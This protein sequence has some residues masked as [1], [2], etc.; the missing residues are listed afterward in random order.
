MPTT[1]TTALDEM[2]KNARALRPA[3]RSRRAETDQLRRL[4]QASVEDILQ[5][6][7][8]GVTTPV[9][10]GGSDLG[11]SAVFE[12]GKELAQGCAAT[13]WIGGNWA[14]HSTLAAMFS[15]EAQ[16]ELFTDGR[17]PLIA[18]AFSPLRAKTELVNGGARV[19]GQ[20]DFAS[21]I[22]HSDWVVVQAMTD[23]GPLA[24]L[25][26]VADIEVIETWRTNGLRGSGSNDVTA[27]EL[28]VPEHRL[29]NLTQVGDGNSMGADKYGT[30]T[31]RLPLAQ[32]FSAG[33]LAALV[34]CSLAAID[35][36]TERTSGNVGG[37]SGLTVATRPEVQLKL[38]RAA[39]DVDGVLATV[40]STYA[41]MDAAAT[42]GEV[43]TV[44]ERVRWRRNIAWAAQLATG[45]LTGLY[46][47]GGAHSLYDG[48]PLEQVF[49]DGITA[50]HHFA[51]GWDQ[52]YV[53]S[54]KA[55]LGEEPGIVMI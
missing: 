41:E 23:T 46:E 18:T 31:L 27:K 34:G 50:S 9:E 17:L 49:R 10:L 25:V 22:L 39:A 47:V 53:G 3:L 28:F 11:A 44:G 38:G 51:F 32:I 26:P 20:W 45:V 5:L 55:M 29:L 2:L 12:V 30:T 33:I 15:Q 52:L 48:D 40:R 42:A 14:V 8:V 21:G 19:S 35:A 16:G 1:V 43:L 4:P 36:F 13:A 37:L 24:H 54:G 6:G 7:I